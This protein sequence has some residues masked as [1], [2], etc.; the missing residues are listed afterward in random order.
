MTLS[1]ELYTCIINDGIKCIN[2]T[3]FSV[4]FKKLKFHS[5]SYKQNRSTEGVFKNQKSGIKTSSEEIGLNIIRTHA[6]PSKVEQDQVHGE[7]SALCWYAAAL[8]KFYW[9]LAQ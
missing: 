2:I 9:S 8:Q 4:R 5:I 1:Y 7:V 6:G 3:Y